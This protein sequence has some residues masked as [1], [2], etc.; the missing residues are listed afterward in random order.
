MVKI[1]T[2]SK[3]PTIY[4]LRLLIDNGIALSMSRGRLKSNRVYSKRQLHC[5]W[6]IPDA[7]E[8]PPPGVSLNQVRRAL[9]FYSAT[10]VA[11]WFV[12]MVEMCCPK[13]GRYVA[14]VSTNIRTTV[15]Y[16]T[17]QW[18]WTLMKL[19]HRL[20]YKFK[21]KLRRWRQM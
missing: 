16:Q 15:V 6:R 5:L 2:Y 12:W 8:P 10:C 1:V 13:L 7:K 18:S 17:G 14:L 3:K 4:R 19:G 20:D 9:R 11:I 21:K